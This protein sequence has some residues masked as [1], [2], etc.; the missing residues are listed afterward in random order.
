MDKIKQAAAL[1]A[2]A[3][4]IPT[5]VKLKWCTMWDKHP[6]TVHRYLKG[7]V[8]CCVIADNMLRYFSDYLKTAK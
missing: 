4:K 8:K 5:D 1:M 2:I 7:K 3:D 6:S